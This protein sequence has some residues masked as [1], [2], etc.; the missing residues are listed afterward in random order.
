[1]D[2]SDVVHS[3][4]YRSF[5]TNLTYEYNHLIV[6]NNCILMLLNIIYHFIEYIQ[7]FQMLSFYWCGKV[8]FFI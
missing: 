5:Q 4:T 3:D 2:R 7:F 8:D 6:K 1:M